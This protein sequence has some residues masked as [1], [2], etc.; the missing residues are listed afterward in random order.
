MVY[1]NFHHDRAKE[2]TKTYL[3]SSFT[4]LNNMPNQQQNTR[5][6]Y[7]SRPTKVKII[8]T[9]PAAAG[10]L[11]NAAWRNHVPATAALE[12]LDI[13][14]ENSCLGSEFWEAESEAGYIPPMQNFWSVD[15]PRWADKIISL[16]S[17]YR[18]EPGHWKFWK[19]WN[20]SCLKEP[21]AE[22]TSMAFCI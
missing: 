4:R 17:Y 14:L 5:R 8:C 22:I 15:W 19:S 16:H 13:H 11:L 20:W 9:V 18:A 3:F 2:K 12:E 7:L 6:T 21:A 1:Q 10:P